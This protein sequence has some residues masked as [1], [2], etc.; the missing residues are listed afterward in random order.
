[1]DR[2]PGETETGV[3]ASPVE[4]DAADGGRGRLW[5]RLRLFH[6]HAHRHLGKDFVFSTSR[7]E[8][9]SSFPHPP[10]PFLLLLAEKRR[11]QGSRVAWSD[12][13][14][15]LARWRGQMSVD[16]R[17]AGAVRC[18]SMSGRVVRSDVREGRAWR[19]CP[20]SIL[21]QMSGAHGWPL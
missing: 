16:E 15:G 12:V 6:E 19:A 11:G 14:D 7:L 10:Q 4:G 8:K 3:G 21:G 9:T 18:P 2:C 1:M 17:A 20:L 13:R 5:K